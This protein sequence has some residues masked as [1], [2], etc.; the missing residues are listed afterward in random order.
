MLQELF[1]RSEALGLQRLKKA[2]D[3]GTK[4]DLKAAS[5]RGTLRGDEINKCSKKP[6]DIWTK[7]D[8]ISQNL[9]EHLGGAGLQRLRT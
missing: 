5:A 3:I 7:R 4:R 1:R 2:W 8:L 9:A 6:K